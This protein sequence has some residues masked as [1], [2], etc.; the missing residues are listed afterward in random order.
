MF[1]YESNQDLN[2]L[3]KIS[4]PPSLLEKDVKNIT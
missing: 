2:E 1:S 3:I 4:R